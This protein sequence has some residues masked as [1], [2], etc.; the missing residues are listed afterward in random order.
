M[1]IRSNR[2]SQRFRRYDSSRDGDCDRVRQV[3]AAQFVPRRIQIGLYAGERQIQNPSDVVICLA[4]RGP[5]QTLLLSFR[6]FDRP[7]VSLKLM[8][9][10]ESI[11]TA[12]G[13]SLTIFRDLY[14]A[15]SSF[16]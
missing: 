2:L 12:I 8:P 1:R 4:S 15:H 9:A 11:K 13:W 14:S 7:G 6:Q 16:E 10:A 3:Y 5:D